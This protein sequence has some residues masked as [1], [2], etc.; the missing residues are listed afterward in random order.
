MMLIFAQSN[1][2]LNSTLP[3]AS[4]SNSNKFQKITHSKPA[5]KQQPIPNES[6]STSKKKGA[7]VQQ[8]HSNIP[9]LNWSFPVHLEIEI[10]IVD[11]REK[12]MNN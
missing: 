6:K 4:Y 9:L 10:R 7:K 12:E 2:T 11:W 3:I 5:Q 8:L 1:L